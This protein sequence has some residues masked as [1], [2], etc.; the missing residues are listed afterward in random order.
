MS[1][2]SDKR[3]AKKKA[4]KEHNRKIVAKQK[5]ANLRKSAHD[6]EEK[7]S[8]LRDTVNG[9]QKDIREQVA[10]IDEAKKVCKALEYFTHTVVSKRLDI[11]Y[12]TDEVKEKF[13]DIHTRVN[14]TLK[15]ID[16][17]RHQFIEVTLKIQ[18]PGVL[19]TDM[20]SLK[21]YSKVIEGA[22]ELMTMQTNLV[23]F[24]ATCTQIIRD[25]TNAITECDQLRKDFGD[26]SLMPV[27]TP[28]E[29]EF[30]GMKFDLET[31]EFKNKESDDSVEIPFVNG[32][33]P[34]IVEEKEEEI[35]VK[36]E[37]KND[38][39]EEAEIVTNVNSVEKK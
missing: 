10:N 1:K 18:D 24:G 35:V 25:I 34:E 7:S 21:K 32:H 19:K 37:S 11:P 14:D 29:R 26:I 12:M 36:E 31:Y 27:A 33:D 2:R 9:I 38:E 17:I 23:D 16:E 6:T 15:K 28:E 4:Q 13:K 22:Q 20:E 5:V 39:I 3:R 8:D 30:L